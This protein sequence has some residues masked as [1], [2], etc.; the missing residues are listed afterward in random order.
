[1]FD[2]LIRGL[3]TYMYRYILYIDGISSMSST[4]VPRRSWIYE[5]M[6][7]RGWGCMVYMF[8]LLLLLMLWWRSNL[9][10]FVKKWAV[11][12]DDVCQFFFLILEGIDTW[13]SNLIW[14]FN[15]LPRSKRLSYPGCDMWPCG[16]CDEHEACKER[17]R[18][19]NELTISKGVF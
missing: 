6:I 11:T 16:P 3:Y 13:T 10:I 5:K 4:S 9:N 7:L 19:C 2:Y 12:E 17:C 8:S 15:N 14:L 18:F 1:M